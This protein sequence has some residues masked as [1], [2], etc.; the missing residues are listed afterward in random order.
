MKLGRARIALLAAAALVALDAVPT[1]AVAKDPKDGKAQDDSLP[2]PFGASDTLRD[3]ARDLYNLGVLGVKV[4]DA[5][6]PL[7]G[8]MTEGK[9]HFEPSKEAGAESGPARKRPAS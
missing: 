8:P 6:A 3:A 5:D 4:A 7:P 1:R 9:H 2:W